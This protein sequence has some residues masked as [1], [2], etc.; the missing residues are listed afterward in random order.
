MNV[1]LTYVFETKDGFRY[2]RENPEEIKELV[3]ANYDA[4]KEIV[5]DGDSLDMIKDY[6]NQYMPE[7][8]ITAC[9]DGKWMVYKLHT[10]VTP[11]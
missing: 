10:I 7:A 9:I 8:T 2:E 1:K 3:Q 11:I 6:T 5:R 4:L